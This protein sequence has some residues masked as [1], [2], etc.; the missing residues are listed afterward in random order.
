MCRMQPCKQPA[1]LI[2]K[3]DRAS[4]SNIRHQPAKTGLLLLWLSCCR[5]QSTSPSYLRSLLWLGCEKQSSRSSPGC[6]AVFTESRKLI[7]VAST[8]VIVVIKR[9]HLHLHHR[10]QQEDTAT[11]LLL[12]AKSSMH[13]LIQ[14]ISNATR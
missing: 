11:D 8:I 5:F 14:S 7:S 10:Q 9:H 2:D 6:F 3:L 12:I 13:P 1:W 4:A